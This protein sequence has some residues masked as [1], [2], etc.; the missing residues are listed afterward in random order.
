MTQFVL[1]DC[2]SVVCVCTGNRRAGAMTS[3]GDA[4]NNFIS[5]TSSLFVVLL[6]SHHPSLYQPLNYVLE[7]LAS[8]F[9]ST[10]VG[11]S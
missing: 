11:L 8:E 5:T 3:H 6:L 1:M 7:V 4:V 10:C 2:M 9:D